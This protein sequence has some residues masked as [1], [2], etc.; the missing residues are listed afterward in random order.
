MGRSNSD[1]SAGAREDKGHTARL[2]P[3]A[4]DKLYD[5]LVL[6]TL[7]GE[8]E[9]ITRADKLVL[10]GRIT[11]AQ[12]GA[13]IAGIGERRHL[14]QSYGKLD[15]MQSLIERQAEEIRQ[16]RGRL[17]GRNLADVGPPEDDVDKPRH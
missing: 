7:K 3:R 2:T 16:L 13:V 1:K 11:R 14:V 10:Q 5:G 4:V 8:S 17:G 9:L 6:S 12:H 15:E